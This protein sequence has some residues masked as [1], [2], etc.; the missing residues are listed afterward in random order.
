MPA[1]SALPVFR[2]HGPLLQ[3]RRAAHH[4][5]APAW[6][7]IPGRSC[8]LIDGYRCAQPILRTSPV[9]ANSGNT[10]SFASRARSYRF[11]QP[12]EW[13]SLRHKLMLK[14]YLF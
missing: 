14:N 1:I 13:L 6:E 10:K 5:H 12:W 7:C 4:S 3:M 11:D 9:L 2:G 8:V